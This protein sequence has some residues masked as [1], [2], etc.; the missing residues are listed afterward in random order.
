MILTIEEA[1]GQLAQLLEKAETGQEEIFISRDGLPVI[2]LAPVT[3]AVGEHA[4]TPSKPRV[5]G[6]GKGQIW[7]APDFNAPLPDDII[8]DFYN[9]EIFPCKP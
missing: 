7:M 1:S 8:D 5:P 9:G 2:R 4:A 3:A 6:L